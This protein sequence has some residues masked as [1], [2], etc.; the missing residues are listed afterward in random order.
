MCTGTIMQ[1]RGDPELTNFEWARA[2]LFKPLS[3]T[4][5]FIEPQ[6]NTYP[7]GG[8]NAY[9]TSRDWLRF[10][11]LYERDGVWVDGTRI[12]PEGWVDFTRTPSTVNPIYGAHFWVS[13]ASVQPPFFCAAGFRYEG[14]AHKEKRGKDEDKRERGLGQTEGKGGCGGCACACEWGLGLGL[15]ESG[16]SSLIQDPVSGTDP[17]TQPNPTQRR[18]PF[19]RGAPH[20]DQ[21]VFIIPAKRL[22]IARH[23]MPSL[24]GSD[25]D[26]R[27][28]LDPIVAAFPDVL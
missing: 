19:G 9:M 3:M 8:S 24:D 15:A 17:P 1:Q 16:T 27:A 26:L 22:V 18:H 23:A 4:S 21:N 10:G 2:R 12:L 6:A 11:L 20:S 14:G 13:E 25:W 5:A 7:L 28:F